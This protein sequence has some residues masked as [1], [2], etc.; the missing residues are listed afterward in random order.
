MIVASYRWPEALQTSL[1]T[2][3]A[4]TIEDLES[5]S[6]L[7]RP[8]VRDHC[9]VGKEFSVKK[10]DLYEA[11]C[12]WANNTHANLMSMEKELLATDR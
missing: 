10:Q 2:A 12:R 7:V 6:S 1:A 5:A 11:Y 9:K 3:L 8:F 4:Q